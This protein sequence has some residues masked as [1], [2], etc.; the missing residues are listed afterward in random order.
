[1]KEFANTFGIIALAFAVFNILFTLLCFECLFIWYG[2]PFP[3]GA[4]IFGGLGIWKDI[5]PKISKTGVILGIILL[6]VNISVG[7]YYFIQ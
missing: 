1:M 6:I 5:N 3:I 4:I 7:I 2:L